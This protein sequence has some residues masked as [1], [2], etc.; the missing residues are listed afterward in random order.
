[1]T[2]SRNS[3]V[4]KTQQRG[5][6]T[7]DLKLCITM[8]INKMLLLEAFGSMY[9]LHL[10]QDLHF[11]MY[12]PHILG[13]IGLDRKLLQQ[14]LQVCRT[15]F[16][17]WLQCISLSQEMHSCGEM[18]PQNN[19][20]CFVLRKI[21]PCFL[22]LSLFNNL[23]SE[24][25]FKAHTDRYFASLMITSFFFFFSFFVFSNCIGKSLE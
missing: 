15:V 7:R 11:A 21:F 3:Q 1:M 13:C 5:F 14:K 25:Y 19:S 22:K 8:C 18:I 17:K 12:M 6:L 2:K 20:Q 23:C 4:C 24:K 9:F 10:E 16:H